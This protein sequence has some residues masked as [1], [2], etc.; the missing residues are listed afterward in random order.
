[1]KILVINGHP[2]PSPERFAAALAAAYATG[3]REGGH[4]VEEIAVGAI[5]APFLANKTEFATPAPAAIEAVQAKITAA[6]HVVLVYPLWLGTMP[7]RLK[8]FLEQ[9][10]RAGFLLAPAPKSNAWPRQMMSGRSARVIVTMGMP[11]FAYRLVFGAHSLKALEGSILRMSG[12]RP[13]RSTVLGGVEGSAE[14]RQRMLRTV[15]KLGRE[16]R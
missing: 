15:T 6:G 16:G 13:V 12:F 1:M 10:A 2:D 3:A 9:V 7:A 14:S 4:E 8:A 5:D 11:G